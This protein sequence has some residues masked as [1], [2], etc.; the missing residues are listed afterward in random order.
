[1]EERFFVLSQIGNKLNN[2]LKISFRLDSFVYVIATGTHFVSASGILND[3]ALFHALYKSMIDAERDTASVCELRKDSLFLCRGRILPNCPHRS[4]R[5]AHDIVIAQK[6]NCARKNHVEEV[7]G[8]DFFHLLLRQHFRF[9][10][11]HI[12]FTP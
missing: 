8:S 2:I 5:V 9:A 11:K 7:L 1:M 6:F 4:I 10:F 12:I 3:F